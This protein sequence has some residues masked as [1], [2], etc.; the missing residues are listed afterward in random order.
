MEEFYNLI[1]KWYGPRQHAGIFPPKVEELLKYDNSPGLN[2][3]RADR[4]KRLIYAFVERQKRDQ[5][6]KNPID[7]IANTGGAST[8]VSSILSVKMV[9]EYTRYPMKMELD[10]APG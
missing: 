8:F 1:H 4:T 9:D 2:L 3:V 5:E 10:L 7:P 6:F